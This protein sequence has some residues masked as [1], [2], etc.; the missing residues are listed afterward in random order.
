MATC[1]TPSTTAASLTICRSEGERRGAD[2]NNPRFTGPQ[3]TAE[4]NA[5]TS[6]HAT[7]VPVE[8]GGGPGT[9][10]AHLRESVFTNEL[11]TGYVGPGRDLPLSR[12][13]IASLADLGYQVNVGAADPF[14]VG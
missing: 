2:T 9:R 6:G 7:S 1:P 12:I 3:A 4:Y 14:R 5:F 11:M 8:N 10:D 13:T